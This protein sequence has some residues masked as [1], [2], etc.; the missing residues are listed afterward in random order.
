MI[1]L[2][3]TAQSPN[4]NELAVRVIGLGNAGVSLTDRLL[5]DLGSTVEFVA[6][7]TDAKSLTSSVCDNKLIVGQ[8]T[9][10][11]LGAGGD[12]ELAAVAL[13]ESRDD[14]RAAVTDTAAVL[15]LGGLGGGT[16]SG[17]LPGMARLARES[18]A[19]AV[20]VV[21]LPFSF[22]GKRRQA[23][24]ETAL[25]E[26]QGAADL[27]IAFENNR[28]SELTQ[29]N[30]PLNETFAESERLLASAVRAL[31]EI[32][33]GKG[34]MQ[35]T[36]G[37]LCG[38]LKGG[39]PLCLFGLGEATGGNRAHEAVARALRSPLLDRGRNL[40]RCAALLLHAAG[41]ADL[42][43]AEVQAAAAEVAKLTEAHTR[44]ALGIS[45]A[46]PA[47]S[48]LR[49]SLLGIEAL[50]LPTPVPAPPPVVS[51]PAP[52]PVPALS[53]EPEPELPEPAQEVESYPTPIEESA[54]A[55]DTPAAVTDRDQ[56]EL[57]RV[58]ETPQSPRPL[59][60]ST[61]RKSAP[62]IKQETLQFEPVARGRFEK[63]EPTIIEGEDLDV[64][65]YLRL[66]I[67]L[68]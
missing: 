16:A 36:L 42:S 56:S 19:F 62:K 51:R 48:P 18:G 6:I 66:K 7:N 53:R 12:P 28:M 4:L 45:T 61:T 15:L 41:P 52:I 54:E 33:R 49:I 3:R 47:G 60:L 37:D 59:P 10:R 57:F 1:E 55:G 8:R 39:N 2:H 23:Q 17:L 27:V 63:S 58:T 50:T 13:D 26:L 30:G 14:L 9:T 24:A 67:R 34:P 25:Q 11:G 31:I 43:Y 32:I 20:A 21:T 29:P 5:L 35:I 64:P 68:K 46:A 65:T 44:I 40:E 22:E 38:Y